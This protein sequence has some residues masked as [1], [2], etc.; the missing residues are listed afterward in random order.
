MSVLRLSCRMCVYAFICVQSA[1][2]KSTTKGAHTKRT[3]DIMNALSPNRN[4]NL[5]R[6]HLGLTIFFLFPLTCAMLELKRTFLFIQKYRRF[7]VAVWLLS[8]VTPTTLVA[9]L[10]SPAIRHSLPQAFII[11]AHRKLLCYR[12][13][14]VYKRIEMTVHVTESKFG[15]N[16]STSIP[17]DRLTLL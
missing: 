5:K 16:S 8:I 6:N 13:I 17:P 2:S 7:F 11:C 14:R 3:S 10:T 4:R 15:H 12:Q 1:N 9:V